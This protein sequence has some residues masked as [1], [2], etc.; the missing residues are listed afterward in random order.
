MLQWMGGSRRKVTTSRKSTHKRQK[1]YFEQRK[2]QQ[3][4]LVAGLEN[5]ADGVNPANRH[6]KEQRSLD[7]LSLLNLSTFAQECNGPYPSG[8]GDME[9]KASRLD[10]IMKGLPTKP[11]GT[12]ASGDSIEITRT[13][14]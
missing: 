8:R 11:N 2:R 14:T 1:Q 7:I 12:T 5:N 10:H 6:Q 3:Q 4:E 9:V 13:S